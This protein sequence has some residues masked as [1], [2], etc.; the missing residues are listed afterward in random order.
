MIFKFPK[1][2]TVR[3]KFA[4]FPVFI[5]GKGRIW[6]EKYIQV[7]ST[8]YGTYR[9]SGEGDWY[10]HFKHEYTTEEWEYILKNK[11]LPEKPAEK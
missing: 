10:D 1:E 7:Y 3:I 4:L 11:I 5:Y 9:G 6:L 2:N 8:K